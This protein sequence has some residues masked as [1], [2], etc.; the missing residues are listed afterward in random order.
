MA[1][2]TIPVSGIEGVQAKPL[3]FEE[4]LGDRRGGR[5]KLAENV[6]LDRFFIY[7]AQPS[8]LQA[9][10]T[11]GVDFIFR[12]GS[13]Y[14]KRSIAYDLKGRYYR[15]LGVS[16]AWIRKFLESGAVEELALV[17]PDLFLID[18]TEVTAIARVPRI[19]KLAPLLKVLGIVDVK[20][21]KV[22]VHRSESGKVTWNRW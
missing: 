13:L 19:K 11:Q 6:P 15:R 7:F 10:L 20:E 2:K 21:G 16:E 4:M 14:Q 17:M 9:F 3:P 12:S 22:T 5:L 1:E 18:G 8:A